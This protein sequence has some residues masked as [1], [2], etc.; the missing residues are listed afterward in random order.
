MN[1]FKIELKRAVFNKNMLIAIII[2][3]AIVLPH[4]IENFFN[5]IEAKQYF[6]EAGLA[7]GADLTS[8]YGRWFGMTTDLLAILFYYILPALSVF[9]GAMIYYKDRKSG[10]VKNLYTR[11]SKTKCLI[12]KYITTFISGG[13]VI[14]VPL[15]SA[16]LLTALYAP[17]RLPDSL[18]MNAIVDEN[19]WSELFFTNPLLYTMGYVFIDFIYGGLFACLAMSVS[20]YVKH[21]FSVFI[22]SFLVVAALGFV[23]LQLGFDSLN[24]QNFLSPAQFSPAN[25]TVV[26]V[27]AIIIL[28][29]SFSLFFIGGKL[30]ETY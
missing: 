5:E 18:V 1:V 10:Y 3:L 19:M 20:E 22:S 28:A 29:T 4:T 2:G 13:I 30:N 16:F 11:Y 23:S 15:L 25:G 26:L 24:P 17:A 27:E 6:A 9:P 21:K 12:I 14:I 7:V 8:L